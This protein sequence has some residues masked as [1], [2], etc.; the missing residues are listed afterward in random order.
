MQRW[1]RDALFTTLLACGCCACGV[2]AVREVTA[3]P[4]L[5]SASPASGIAQ[6]VSSPTAARRDVGSPAAARSATPIA[7]APAALHAPLLAVTYT[8][9]LCP[10][11]PCQGGFV[12]DR[13]GAFVATEGAT[14]QATHQLTR[15]ELVDLVALVDHADYARLRAKP[16]TGLCPSAYDGREVIYTFYS[17]RGVERLSSCEVAIDQSTP[18][19]RKVEEVRATYDR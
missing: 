17:A 4:M 2:T 16:F 13:A 15:A 6:P 5:Q 12:I 10:Y 7:T 8:G 19:F 14:V 9:G 3:V 1:L 11:G 18:L